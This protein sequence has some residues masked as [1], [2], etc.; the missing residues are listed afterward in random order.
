MVS[1]E[2]VLQMSYYNYKVMGLNKNKTNQFE[3][4]WR[5]DPTTLLPTLWVGTSLGSVLTVSITL[6]DADLRKAQPVVVS[7]LGLFAFNIPKCK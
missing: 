3:S 4:S 2:Y 6:P 5:K 1:Y 7:I